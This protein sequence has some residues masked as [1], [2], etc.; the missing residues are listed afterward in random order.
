ML[1][2]QGMGSGEG[3]EMD[4]MEYVQVVR[5]TSIAAASPLPIT[6]GAG[7]FWMD[8]RLCVRHSRVVVQIYSLGIPHKGFELAAA[9]GRIK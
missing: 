7:R 5:Q 8:P 1:Y 4:G 6:A 3:Q 2:V 9:V